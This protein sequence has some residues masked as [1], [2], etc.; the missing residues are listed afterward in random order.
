MQFGIRIQQLASGIEIPLVKT[1]H[2]LDE[3]VARIFEADGDGVRL[4]QESG[5]PVTFAE[6]GEVVDPTAAVKRALAEPINFP[7]LAAGIVPG[8]RFAIAV[9]SDV[10]C[11]AS[12]VRGAVE[13]IIEAGIESQDIS[14]VTTDA[15]VSQLCRDELANVEPAPQFVVHDPAD[16]Q[17]LCVIGMMKPGQLVRVNRTIFEAEV[18]LPI[19]CARVRGRGAYNSLYPAFFSADAVAK[20]R[21]PSMQKE[22]VPI[23]G[24]KSEADEAGWMVGPPMTVQVVPATNDTV[25][26]VLAGE[27]R[28]VA[29]QG[30]RLCRERW[31]LHSPQHVSLLVA[32]VTGGSAA[33]TWENIGRALAM[34]ERVVGEDGAVAICSNLEEAPG[35]SLGRLIRSDDLSATQRKISHDH[36]TDT[37]TAWRLARALLRGPVYF[38]SQLNVDTV[39]DLGLAPVESV[40]DLV[41]LASR[42]ESFVV[43]ADSQHAVVKVDDESDDA[44]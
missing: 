7:P 39:E 4:T 43:V 21:T 16:E 22:V 1:L 2:P 35:Q 34:A 19:A 14:I 25:A 17:N 23:K 13:A 8:D 15:V 5:E 28:A 12:I 31:L 26:H 33:Q 29:R 37:W 30:R 41:R 6:G 42:H 36:A 9:D 10:P 27:P 20:Y 38:L 3:I 32:T 44:E 40:D 24:K 11:V 18:V